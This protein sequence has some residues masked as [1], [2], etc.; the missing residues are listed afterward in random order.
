DTAQMNNAKSSA[1]RIQ[2]LFERGIATKDQADQSRTSAAALEATVQADKA[3][4]DNAKVQLAYASIPAEISGRTGQLQVHQGNLVRANDNTALVVIN[5]VTPINVTF[6]IPEAQLPDLKRYM[7]QGAVRVEAMPPNE[8][9]PSQ[10]TINFVDNTV[11][12]TTGQIKVK[13]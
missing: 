8:T 12:Q 4:V 13:G 11:D 5:Q 9:T 2:E 3:A 10:G 1:S 6:G 7:L